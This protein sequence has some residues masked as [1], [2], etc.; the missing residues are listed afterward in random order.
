MDIHETE[1]QQVEA[2][3]KWWKDNGSSI[4]TGILLGLAVVFAGKSWLAYQER[5]S[6]LA[7]DIYTGM[8]AALANE[9]ETVVT[10]QA[11]ILI[12]NYPDTP[13]APIAALALAKLR[14]ANGDLAAARTQLQW[15]LDN[16][17]SGVLRQTV[18]L[19]LAHVM[20]AEGDLDAAEALLVDVVPDA[21][22]VPLYAD[23]RGDIQLAR[24]NIGDA[25]DEYAQALTLMNPN[26]PGRQLLQLK[27]DDIRLPEGEPQ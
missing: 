11:G 15:A 4:I 22:F 7:S 26:A 6:Q 17:G 14:L 20:V 21:A 27:H 3:K 13:Y 23:L 18:R 1:E 9:K 2:L 5:Q 16:A 24:G 12:A 10:E 25:R 8:M 19:R